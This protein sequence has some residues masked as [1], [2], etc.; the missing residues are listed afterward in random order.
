MI[1]PRRFWADVTIAPEDG[2][3]GL[4]LDN[5]PLRTPA[6]A[7]LRVPTHG[8]AEAIAVEWR[9]IGDE[10][11]PEALPFTRAAN[12]AIDRVARDPGPVVAQVARYGE[13]DLLCYLTGEP[14]GLRRRQTEGWEPVLVWAATRLDAPLRTTIGVIHIAQ[15][16]GS[17]AALEAAVA[18]LDPFALTALHELVALSGSLLLGLAVARGAREP[19]TAWDLSRIDE[20]WQA[21]QWG[22]DAEAEA[23]AALKRADFLRA[24]LML[25][26][27]ADRATSA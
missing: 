21:E 13:T 2:G 19:E 27:L 26:L 5:R 20:I 25:E 23:A 7:A 6:H 10:I 11:V 1:A 9:E 3:F 4:R 14:E 16:P 15:P 8:F 17:L 22:A 18:A 24:G 12:V